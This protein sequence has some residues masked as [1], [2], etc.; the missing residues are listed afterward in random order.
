MINFDVIDILINLKE[1]ENIL[2]IIDIFY[3]KIYKKWISWLFFSKIIFINSYID[4]NI[5]LKINNSE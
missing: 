5:N 2:K 4:L 1:N 3:W